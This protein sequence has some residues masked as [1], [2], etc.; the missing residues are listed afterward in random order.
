MRRVALRVR[1]ARPADGPAVAALDRAALPEAQAPVDPAAALARAGDAL[2]VAET[3]A[4]GI[5]GFVLSR[6]IDA[7][8][9]I[10]AL[11]VA[12]G[13]RRAG[14]GEA[15]LATALGGAAREGAR[16]AFLEVR[17]SAAGALA[18]YAASGFREIGRRP[19]YYRGREDAI[20]M[21][22]EIDAADAATPLRT[23]GRVVANERDGGTGLRLSL[24]VPGWPGSAPGQ[25]VMLS[26]GPRGG[27]PRSDPLLPRP[28]AVYR[29]RADGETFD[30]LYKVVGR[31]TRLLAD[32]VPGDAVG[33]VGPLGRGFAAPAS[34]EHALLVGGGTGTASLLEQAARAPRATVLLGARTGDDL[35]GVAEFRALDV[36]LELATEDGSVGH[37][38]LVTELLAKALS[39]ASGAVVYACGPTPMMRAAAALA[40]EHGAPCHVSL[41]NPMACGFGVCLGC[42][43]PLAAGGFALV[44]R[45]GP[46][47]DADAVDWENLA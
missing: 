9:E 46:V 18:F 31:G 28:M 24:R 6:R 26:P 43:A 23:V 35:I 21:S 4:D 5:V 17:A 40:R 34:D 20:L 41:E 14:I 25:F 29:T 39:A 16:T 44:C 45:D 30:V 37:H 3:P 38:G 1:A 27:V 19:R 42:A 2:D 13:R 11:A 15:L 7:E 32:A 8:L 33:V 12:A 22:R 36:A 47:F 10:H